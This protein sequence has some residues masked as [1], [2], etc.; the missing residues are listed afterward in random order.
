[1]GGGGFCCR[2]EVRPPEY[3]GAGGGQGGFWGVIGRFLSSCLPLSTGTGVRAAKRRSA[4][5]CYNSVTVDEVDSNS[6]FHPSGG[7]KG[8]PVG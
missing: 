1:L 4:E 3:L 2:G 6:V 8:G 5:T 7:R